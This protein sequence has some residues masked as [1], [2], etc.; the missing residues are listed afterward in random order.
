MIR[1]FFSVFLISCS[2]ILGALSSEQ[3][4]QQL[5]EGNKR[6][7]ANK[8]IS[9]PQDF[10][11]K[12]AVKG[13]A[14][15]AVI[16]ACADS[17]VAPEILFDQG[18]GDLFVV[19]VAGNVIGPLE[20]ESIEYAA[21]YLGSS[22]ILVMGHQ[23][24]GAVQAVVEGQT[25]DIRYIAQLIKKSVVQAR[26]SRSKD[27]LKT[28]IELNA[29]ATSRF[30]QESFIISDLMDQKKVDVGAAYYDFESGKVHFL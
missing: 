28:A 23:N 1:W 15:F 6:F 2:T 20:M 26:S 27:L 19:R 8:T 25:A 5:V 3:A 29:E 9:K 21:K 18:I 16:V 17:R 10:L 13:Q 14:P 12:K 4:L 30:V 7:Q 24:C 22:Y 11:R